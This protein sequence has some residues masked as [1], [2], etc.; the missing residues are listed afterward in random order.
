MCQVFVLYSL[1][2]QCFVVSVCSH[3]KYS[4]VVEVHKL[5]TQVKVP[6]QRRLHCK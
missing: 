6:A 2:L 5:N 3:M 1:L 4:E